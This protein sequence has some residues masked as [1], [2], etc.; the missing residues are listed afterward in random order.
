M[1]FYIAWGFGLPAAHSLNLGPARLI[2]QVIFIV[3]TIALGVLMLIF[4]CILSPEIRKAWKSI[5]CCLVPGHSK[6]HIIGEHQSI[7]NVHMT[8][9]TAIDSNLKE[10][11][12]SEVSFTFTDNTLE[13]PVAANIHKD[14][15]PTDVEKELEGAEDGDTDLSIK[16]NL[17]AVSD[18]PDDQKQSSL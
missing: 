9:C 17:S 18:D 1:L 4:F 10:E 8:D 14:S 12:V 7:K 5:F 6:K 13:N 16:T 2:F 3:A 11:A 15:M